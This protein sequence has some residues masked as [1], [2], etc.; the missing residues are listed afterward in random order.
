[1]PSPRSSAALVFLACAIG[2]AAAPARADERWSV[3]AD[4]LAMTAPALPGVVLG[5]ALG[6]RR[7]VSGPLHLSLR[8]IAG[9][10]SDSNATWAISQTHVL[11][12]GGVGVSRRLGAAELSADLEAGALAISELAQRHQ[13]V[14]LTAAQIPDRER[15]ALALAP[16]AALRFGVAI[17]IVAHWRLRLS[18][19]PDLTWLKV[20]DVSRL[21]SGLISSA[22]VSHAF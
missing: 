20:G 16:I 14:R 5:A 10:T 19:G 1:M 18:L 13:L 21:R 3:S 22:G 7:V 2:A 15:S 11:A 9:S 6:A 17:E 12:L 8:L 4:V